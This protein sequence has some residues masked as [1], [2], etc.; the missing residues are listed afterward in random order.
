MKK[1]VL[2]MILAALVSPAF[3]QG[4]TPPTGGNQGGAPAGNSGNTGKPVSKKHVTHSTAPTKHRKAG[5]QK[6]KLGTTPK[7]DNGPKK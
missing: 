1:I 7:D 4:G 5:K 3:A 2:S 6:S